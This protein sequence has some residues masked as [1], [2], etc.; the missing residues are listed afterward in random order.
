M[1][2]SF[3]INANLWTSATPITGNVR[4]VG[5]PTPAYDEWSTMWGENQRARF[6]DAKTDQS[7]FISAINE[8]GGCIQICVSLG[9]RRREGLDYVMVRGTWRQQ[10]HAVKGVEVACGWQKVP[11]LVHPLT[12]HHTIQFMRPRL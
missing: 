3:N 7:L 8:R 12:P 5:L 6:R 10:L 2:L 9:V 4:A 1:L 11:L